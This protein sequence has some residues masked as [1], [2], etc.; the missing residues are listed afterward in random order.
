M[1]VWAFLWPHEGSLARGQSWAPTCPT[2][3]SWKKGW[4][5]RGRRTG[6]CQVTMWRAALRC[7]M[8]VTTESSFIP[9]ELGNWVLERWNDYARP[10]LNEFCQ[11]FRVRSNDSKTCAPSSQPDQLSGLASR[12]RL[13]CWSCIPIPSHP[14]WSSCL[15]PPLHLR[16][17][18][19]VIK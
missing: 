13:G 8:V 18:R 4:R 3:N 9:R 15:F 14:D 19:L 1:R 2:P 7:L 11:E 17:L 16:F 6:W 5:W 12:G 10:T